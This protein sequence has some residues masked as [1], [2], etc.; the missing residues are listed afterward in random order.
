MKLNNNEIAAVKDCLKRYTKFNN[1]GVMS[2][3]KVKQSS[4]IL[5]DENEIDIEYKKMIVLKENKPVY[6]IIKRYSSKTHKMLLPKIEYIGGVEN[7]KKKFDL[8]KEVINDRLKM[9]DI[10][11]VIRLVTL[12]NRHELINDRVMKRLYNCI[13]NEIYITCSMY[14]EFESLEDK[15]GVDK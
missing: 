3:Y 15:T 1:N 12:Y 6:K 9:D 8:I 2:S 11:P 4:L 14:D 7:D 5:M 13:R 10:G